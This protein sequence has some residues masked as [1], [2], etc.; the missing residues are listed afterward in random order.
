MLSD[1]APELRVDQWIDGAGNSMAQPTL[2]QLGANLKV[3]FCFQHWCPGCHSAGFP[4]LQ[5]LL[6]A[7]APL[8]VGFAVVQTVFEG[9]EQNTFERLR[10]NQQRYEL[11]L[12]FGHDAVAGRRPTIMEDYQTRGTPWF[13]LI[14]AEG[15]I[16]FSDFHINA[17]RLVEHMEQIGHGSD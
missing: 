15:E 5:R 9:F 14:N 1:T 8:G 2:K 7:L 17:D 3:I 16:V 13:I 4:T 12:P 6:P 11:N 10:E